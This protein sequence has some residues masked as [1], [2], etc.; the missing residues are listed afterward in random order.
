MT[1]LDCFGQSSSVE[2][3]RKEMKSKEKRRGEERRKN[4]TEER[5]GEVKWRNL[6][7]CVDCKMK[8]LNE[9]ISILKDFVRKKF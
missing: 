2:K 5:R 1:G 4:K 9:G 8:T 3:K 7:F 6:Y